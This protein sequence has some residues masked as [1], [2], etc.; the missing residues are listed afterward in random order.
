LA[1]TNEIS[2]FC[3]WGVV[4]KKG[5]IGSENISLKGHG[6]LDDETNLSRNG[7]SSVMKCGVG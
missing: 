7:Y 3:L 2:I 1:N 5:R 4:R 6:Y